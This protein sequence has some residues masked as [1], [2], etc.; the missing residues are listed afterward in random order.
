MDALD[1]SLQVESVAVE[2]A[3][4]FFICKARF[5]SELCIS[6]EPK[7]Y[8]ALLGNHSYKVFNTSAFNYRLFKIM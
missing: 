5:S 2:F 3:N 1:V 7:A 6:L 8:Q 4:D